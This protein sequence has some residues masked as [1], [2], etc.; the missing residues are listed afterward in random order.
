MGVMML[1]PAAEGT[2]PMCATEHDPDWP[3]NGQSLFYNMRFKM[4]HG[5]EPTWAD[6]LA[7]CSPAMQSAWREKL[8]EKGVY[9]EPDGEPIA[10]PCDKQSPVVAGS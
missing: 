7:H 6:A 2:C 5:R 9:G 1:L 10:E 4:K 3:H 8:K